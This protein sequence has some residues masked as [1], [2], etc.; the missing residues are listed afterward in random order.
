MQG[1]LGLSRIAEKWM[2]VFG[3]KSCEKELSEFALVG[4]G[5]VA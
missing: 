3:S 5:K 4:E 2:P 1:Y